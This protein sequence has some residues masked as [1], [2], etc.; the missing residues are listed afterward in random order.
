MFGISVADDD[1]LKSGFARF[2]G[3]WAV[4]L[5]SPGSATTVGFD[6]ELGL[7]TPAELERE[8]PTV[9]DEG[10]SEVEVW[11]GVGAREVAVERDRGLCKADFFVT[12]LEGIEPEG[13]DGRSEADDVGGETPVRRGCLEGGEIAD[14]EISFECD[15]IIRFKRS[16]HLY[17]PLN[18]FN[19]CT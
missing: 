4:S 2:G 3:P 12:G 13:V 8:E 1:W 18:S 10:D 9:V 7:G 16:T 17:S 14:L 19:M 5:V 6:D 11:V 15:L